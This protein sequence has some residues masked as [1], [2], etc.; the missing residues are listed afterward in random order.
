MF[1]YDKKFIGSI[2]DNQTISETFVEFH[3]RPL[4]LELDYN[5]DLLLKLLLD[6]NA[7][8]SLS[9]NFFA[10]KAKDLLGIWGNFFI[11]NQ[12]DILSLQTKDIVSDKFNSIGRRFIQKDFEEIV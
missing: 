11:K 5:W 3:A 2:S 1:R 7:L 10:V 4:G 9:N 12:F 8:H 6:N